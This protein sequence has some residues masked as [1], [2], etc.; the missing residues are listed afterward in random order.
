MSAMNVPPIAMQARELLKPQSPAYM[1]SNGAE[2]LSPIRED[3]RGQSFGLKAGCS[4]RSLGVGKASENFH[5]S[6]GSRPSRK[7]WN[8]E[9]T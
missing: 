4:G 2:R 8:V 3:R 1:S 5:W 6:L 9:D 7:V